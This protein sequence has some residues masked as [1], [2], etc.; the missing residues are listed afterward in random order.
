MRIIAGEFRSRR[1]LAPAGE[2]TR[3]ITDRAKQSL[4]DI[5]APQFDSARTARPARPA[6]VYDCFAG[7]GSMGLECISRGAAHATFFEADRSAAA[8]LGK[9]IEMLGVRDRCGIV[10]GDLFKWFQHQPPLPPAQRP[11]LIF[12]DPPYRFLREKPDPLKQLVA[13]MVSDHLSPDGML[14]FRHAAADALDLPPLHRVDQRAYGGMM[15]ELLQQPLP[16]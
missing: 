7:T 2:A 13:R 10:T 5:L 9:N 16:L 14:I 15:I 12:L 1:I 6:R 11:C 8:R 4:F 3:P